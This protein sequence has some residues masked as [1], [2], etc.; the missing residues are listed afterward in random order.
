MKILLHIGLIYVSRKPF[1]HTSPRTICHS[2]LCF[3]RRRSLKMRKGNIWMTFTWHRET[4]FNLS[5]P[6]DQFSYN[7]WY[8]YR[9]QALYS[10]PIGLWYTAVELLP[11]VCLTREAYS[12]M[13]TVSHGDENTGCRAQIESPKTG[14]AAK[15][16]YIRIVQTLETLLF[17]TY[18]YTPSNGRPGLVGQEDRKLTI[19]PV[20]EA[21]WETV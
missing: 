4:S 3:A 2:V 10:I 9:S 5:L 18:V 6:N 12:C 8:L 21:L 13:V 19:Y 1:S 14:M 20:F 17:W 16:W 11:R 15:I 7:W